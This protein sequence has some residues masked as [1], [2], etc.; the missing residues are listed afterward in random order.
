MNVRMEREQLARLDAWRHKQ[1][2]VPNRP[3]AMRRLVEK[4][5]SA[6]RV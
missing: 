4:G 5:L 2:D 1:D 3:E 6:S